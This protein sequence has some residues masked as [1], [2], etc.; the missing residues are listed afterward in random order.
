MRHLFV[1]SVMIGLASVAASGA[2]LTVF[3]PGPAPWDSA[4]AH[5]GLNW[6]PYDGRMF[7]GRVTRTYLRGALDEQVMH[8]A[9]HADINT[10]RGYRR[11][12]KLLTDS[13]A[14]LLDL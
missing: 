3:S 11:R 8:H 2:D 13:P 14:K 1:A 6:S 5:D 4:E 7:A 9:R 10:T 12:A